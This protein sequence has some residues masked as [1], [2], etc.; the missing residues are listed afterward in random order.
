MVSGKYLN[1]ALAFEIQYD[2]RKQSGFSTMIFAYKCF[3]NYGLL[4]YAKAFLNLSNFF[5]KLWDPG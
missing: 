1:M 5:Q 4:T 3:M 2:N